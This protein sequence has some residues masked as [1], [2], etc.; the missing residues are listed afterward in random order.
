MKKENLIS[1]Q[2]STLK[3]R[4]TF[5]ELQVHDKGPQGDNILLQVKKGRFLF[6]RLS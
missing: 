1:L 4:I 5:I 3:R 2:S 6:L